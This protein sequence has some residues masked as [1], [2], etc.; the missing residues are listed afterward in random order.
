MYE[1]PPIDVS[2][3]PPL[4]DDNFVPLD[5]GYLRIGLIGWAIFA[6][7]VA[8][9]GVALATQVDRPEIPLAAMAVL[10]AV[11]GLGA[12]LR[13]LAVR[14][15]AY[16]LRAHDISFR[17]G[18]ISRRV[19]TLPFVRVQHARVTRGGLERLFG[20]ATVHVNSAGPDL[21]I[22]GLRGEDA[23]RI[24]ALVIERAG[25]LDEDAT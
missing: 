11:A 17:R 8:V 24:K 16:Q 7:I 4:A 5:A 12:V 10:L 14:H 13:V 1:N 6:F 9:A 20:L 19:D 25:D 18:V 2:S 3:L 22:P 21:S 15:T 23:D